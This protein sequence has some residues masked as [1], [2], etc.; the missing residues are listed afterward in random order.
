MRRRAISSRFSLQRNPAVFSHRRRQTPMQGKRARGGDVAEQRSWVPPEDWYEPRE[1]NAGHYRVVEQPAGAGYRHVLTV[2]EARERL[3]SLPEQMTRGLEVLQFSRMT[4]KKSTF[5][6]YGMQWG[7]AIYLYPIEEDLVEY[8]HRPP[9]PMQLIEA[10]MHGGVWEQ[11]DE[12]TWRLVWTEEAIKDY[13]LNNI[14]IHEL[15]HLLDDRNSSY[16]ERERFAEWFAIEYGYR[17]SRA[18]KTTN[19]SEKPT[20]RHHKRRF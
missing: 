8:Y 16:L 6:C 4:K 10:K 17:A 9:T 20:R 14:L 1:D 15:G 11:E 19:K 5:P 18:G 13:Y 12:Q 2:N 7:R 3:A